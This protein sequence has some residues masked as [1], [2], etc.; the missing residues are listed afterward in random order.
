M[1]LHLSVALILQ[2]VGACGFF[3]WVDPPLCA[4]ARQIIPGLLKR[5]TNELQGK[6][7]VHRR[8]EKWLFVCCDIID[9]FLVVESET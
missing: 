2:S 3:L 7:Q 4:R 5:S 8:R 9:F 1:T 6:L